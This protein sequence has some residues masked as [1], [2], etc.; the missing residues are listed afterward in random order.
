MNH[1]PEDIIEIRDP[2]IASS[3]IFETIRTNMAK[4]N[5]ANLPSLSHFKRVEMDTP[6]TTTP[7]LNSLML[8]LMGTPP[9]R[10][11][12][13]TSTVPLIGSLLVA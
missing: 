13:F 6:S 12:Q 10:E 2:E 8:Q 5:A 4:R 11:V 7:N 3:A 9:L 1:N